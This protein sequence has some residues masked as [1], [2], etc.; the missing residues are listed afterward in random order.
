[1]S[2]TGQHGGHRLGAGRKKG[3]VNRVS[4]EMREKVIRRGT[5]LDIMMDTVH[6]FLAAA[7]Q[8]T[9]DK[10]LLLLQ[11]A[12]AIAKDAAPYIHPKLS[13]VEQTG[14]DGG[15][16]QHAVSLRVVFVAAP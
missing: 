3:T 11:Q 13:A 2:A 10:R 15:P 7:Q 4:R 12:A 16:V 5:P 8:Q 6:A 1:M 9:G 14:P